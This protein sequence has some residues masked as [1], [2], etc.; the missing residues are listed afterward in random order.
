MTIKMRC[1][2]GQC[3]NRIQSLFTLL[4]WWHSPQGATANCSALLNTTERIDLS[5]QPLSPSQSD[6]DDEER[7][8]WGGEG[9]HDNAS[10]DSTTALK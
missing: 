1:K 7:G 10:R 8:R 9:R 6:Y 3:P 4:G 5:P 2:V